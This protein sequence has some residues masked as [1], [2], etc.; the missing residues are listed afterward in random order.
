MIK[1]KPSII[2]NEFIGLKAKVVRCSNLNVVGIEGKVVNETRNTFEI[3]DKTKSRVVIKDTDIF[4]FTMPDK[5]I[6]EMDGKILVGRP[7]DR[8][9]KRPRRLW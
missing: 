1:V 8:I 4:E 2:Q 6:V 7:E 5:T 9:K 3:I